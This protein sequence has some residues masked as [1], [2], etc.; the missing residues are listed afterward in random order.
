MGGLTL[1]SHPSTPPGQKESPTTLATEKTV[2]SSLTCTWGNSWRDQNGSTLRVR[3][4]ICPK[5]ASTP[6]T[7][8]VRP[9]F[10]Q[11]WKKKEN[12]NKGLFTI[13][14]K[15]K[16]KKKKKRVFPHKKKKKKKKKK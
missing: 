9:G 8:C 4:P 3:R 10:R 13:K 16:K 15:K 1:A 14:K 2:P 12:N 7:P 6:S 5:W 11:K